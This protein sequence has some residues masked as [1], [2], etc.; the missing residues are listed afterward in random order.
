MSVPTVATSPTEQLACLLE[1]R[2]EDIACVIERAHQSEIPEYRS[3]TPEIA[4]ERHGM[5][6]GAVYAATGVMRGTG[7]AF[8]D[9]P[10]IAYGRSLADQ[11]MP[12]HALVQAFQV[13]IR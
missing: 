10:W 8:T 6:V 2:A 9:A 4:A 13:G 5:T 7:P 11:D 3:P 1:A 12:L